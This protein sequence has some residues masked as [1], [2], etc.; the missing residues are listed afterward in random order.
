MTVY[1]PTKALHR[2]LPNV[3]IPF[4]PVLPNV[5]QKTTK[6]YTYSFFTF[7]TSTF[8]SRGRAI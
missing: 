6:S 5:A 2:L 3:T 1:I 4:N 7:C 8:T